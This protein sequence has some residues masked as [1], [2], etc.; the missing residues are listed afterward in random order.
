MNWS[1]SRKSVLTF[2]IL[3]I[4]LKQASPQ[5]IISKTES[6]LIK[7]E[8]KKWTEAYLAN[9]NSLGSTGFSIAEKSKLVEDAILLFENEDVVIYNDL[10]PTGKT[11]KEFK[12]YQYLGNIYTWFSKEGVSFSFNSINVSDIFVSNSKFIF[13]KVHYLRKID[14]V[15]LNGLKIS[16]DVGVDLYIKFYI[17]DNTITL[18]P[19]IYSIAKHEDNLNQFTKAEILDE[20]S[21]SATAKTNLTSVSKENKE[22]E[23]IYKNALLKN[24]Q[25]SEREVEI[26]KEMQKA[27]QDIIAAQKEKEMAEKEKLLSQ[28]K[29]NI[30]D[31][32]LFDGYTSYTFLKFHPIRTMEYVFQLSFE[33]AFERNN[34]YTS[35]E[36]SIGFFND[37]ISYN[38]IDVIVNGEN[39]PYIDLYD[40][41]S[42][43]ESEWSEAYDKYYNDIKGFVSRTVLRFY[44]KPKTMYGP[45][46]STGLMFE[47]FNWSG[48][49]IFDEILYNYNALRRDLGL[50]VLFGWQRRFL[51]SDFAFDVFGGITIGNKKLVRKIYSHQILYEWGNYNPNSLKEFDLNHLL[52][53]PHLSVAISY[54]IGKKSLNKR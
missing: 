32:K 31:D 53:S 41:Y 29:Q 28:W 11:P 8:A 35:F 30:V 5:L 6:N 39:Y 13:L 12:V 19:L 49:K 1:S 15:N 22:A 23:D 9:I 36:Q 18:R 46:L 51:K 40:D 24:K 44:L 47:K 33:H 42:K 48:G 17:Y 52:F 20:S 50:M 38:L 54:R 25:L 3:L 4:F 27:Q 7:N 37:A 14:G 43:G 2:F 16:N 26:N 21:M 45:Y 34:K 10:D